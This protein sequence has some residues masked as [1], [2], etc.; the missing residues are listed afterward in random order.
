FGFVL[1]IGIGLTLLSVVRGPLDLHLIGALGTVLAF[2]LWCA[3]SYGS[4]HW[5]WVLAWMTLAVGIYLA[6]PWVVARFG[7][8]L[9]NAGRNGHI[10]AASLLAVGVFL[11][12]TEPAV[13]FPWTL[14]G[15]ML[16][17]AIEIA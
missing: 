13:V 16:L 17:L 5:P 1:V 12:W 15:I 11:A 7:R 14:F 10:A 2:I 9:G 8:D 6:A 3:T 4:Q